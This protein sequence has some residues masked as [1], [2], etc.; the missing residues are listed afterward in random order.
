[1]YS[2][3]N[4]SVEELPKFKR[5]W[6]TYSGIIASFL[7]VRKFDKATEWTYKVGKSYRHGDILAAVGAMASTREQVAKFKESVA[8]KEYGVRL[9][10]S[11]LRRLYWNGYLD[12][13]LIEFNSMSHREKIFAI[14]SE[15]PFV[16]G[17]KS[18][19]I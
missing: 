12:E 17:C 8:F 13:A 6:V 3:A 7:E 10:R 14:L 16:V 15:A 5:D 9:Q 4:P 19:S 18:C 2:P 11:Y 1:V